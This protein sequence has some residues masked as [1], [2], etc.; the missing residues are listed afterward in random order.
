MKTVLLLSLLCGSS[1]AVT[2]KSGKNPIRTVVTLMQRMQKEVEEEGEKEKELHEKFV[3]YCDT[4]GAS[5]TK[6]NEDAKANIDLLASKLKAES[7]E[8]SQIT[9]ELGDHKTDRVQAKS[10]LEEATSLREKEASEF[11]A[12]KADSETNIEAMNSAIPAIEKGLSSAS[13]LQVPPCRKLKQIVSRA[14]FLDTVDQSDLMSFLE[15]RSNSDEA[16][17]GDSGQ[18]LG[19]LKQMKEEF[20]ANLADA[21]KSEESAVA[22]FAE[23]KASK[24]K[25]IEVATEAIEVKMARTGELAVSISQAK[26]GLEDSNDEVEDSEKGLDSLKK[27][28]DAKEKEYASASKE[29][30][31]EVEALSQAISV[32]NDD[33]ALGLFQKTGLAGNDQVQEGATAF[34]QKASETHHGRIQKVQ[35]LLAS[36]VAKSASPQ[37]NVM[38]V[39]LKSKIRQR[40]TSGA[41]KFEKIQKMIE[42]MIVLLGKQQDEDDKNKEWCRGEFEKAEDEQAATKTEVGRLETS[43][44]EVTDEI[45]QLTDELENLKKQITDLDFTVAEAT[46]QRKEEHTQFQEAVT[47][48]E[49]SIALIAKAKKKLE[50]IYKPALVQQPSSAPKPQ[51]DDEQDGISFVQVK[52]HTWAFEDFMDSSTT[53]AKV[54]QRAAK[55]G[56]VMKLMD[57]IIHDSKMAIKDAESAE[58]E[59]Q[60]DYADVMNE[61]Q[62]Q[63]AADSKAITDKTAAKAE[64][65]AK[66]VKEKEKHAGAVTELLT[67]GK[68]IQDL[69]GEC[70]FILLNYDMRK[71]A[72]SAEM[73]SLKNVKAILA[74]AK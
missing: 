68:L 34:L 22:G 8:K 65:E 1:V 64:G 45:D 71:E 62:V 19:I 30:A 9:Q 31:M 26:N 33:D 38:L 21:I 16:S 70:D 2:V 35:A 23:L 10:D 29:R 36:A 37:F 28:C 24:E 25:E 39:S 14:S 61:A 13:L 11:D 3:C 44:E 55:S 54:S 67:V 72:R 40:S 52:A 56:G 6:V 18:I 42:D 17:E 48:Q 47:M 20:E 4:T 66:L 58:K 15:G 73:D 41:H 43:V 49:A 5:L 32:L 46:V 63:R 60:N 27:Q 51:E 59:A 57:D 53:D 50:K 69:H 74:G 12:M 7:A